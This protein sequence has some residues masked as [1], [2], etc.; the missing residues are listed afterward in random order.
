MCSLYY[1]AG[2][3]DGRAFHGTRYLFLRRRTAK[4]KSLPLDVRYGHAKIRSSMFIQANIVACL[5]ACFSENDTKCP[6]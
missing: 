2:I 4:V 1:E 3:K 6:T 5:V